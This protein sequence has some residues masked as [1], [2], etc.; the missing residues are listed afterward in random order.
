VFAVSRPAEAIARRAAALNVEILR[1]GDRNAF[2][3]P[4]L[5][6]A[7]LRASSHQDMPMIKID[8]VPHLDPEMAAA[9]AENRRLY[10]ELAAQRGPAAPDDVAAQ[11]AFFNHGRAYW[12]A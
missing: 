5:P 11:R 10:G 4:D 3:W 1:H 12:N 2:S 8:V 6:D 9:V 7:I